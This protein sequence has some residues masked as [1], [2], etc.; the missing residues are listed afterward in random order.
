MRFA[1]GFEL[2][3]EDWGMKSPF[4]GMDPYIESQGLW[5]DFHNSLIAQIHHALADSAPE[6]YLVRFGERSYYVLIG[7]DEKDEYPFVPDVKITAP[8]R[9]KRPR[10]K[11]GEVAVAE[12]TAEDEPLTLRACIEEEYRETFVDIYDA[13]P[14]QRLVTTIE[15]LSPSNKRPGTKGWKLY[16]RKRRNVLL[17]D[18]NLVEIDLL[19]G[20]QRPPMLDQWPNSPYT[21]LVAHGASLIHRCKVWRAS[22]QRPVPEIPVPLAEPDADIPLHLQTMIDSIYKRSRYGG[23]I[24]YKKP[25]KPPLR[26]ADSVWVKAQL[27]EWQRQSR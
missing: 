22:F 5:G 7:A 16:Q 10:K 14:E 1:G 15:V 6:R 9:E 4:P 11:S 8:E 25:L 17:G 26:G 18:V 2:S 21:L 23:S 24:N 27:R 3:A 20:G 19:R 12:R 13:E